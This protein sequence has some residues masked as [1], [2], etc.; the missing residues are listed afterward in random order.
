MFWKEVVGYN[1]TAYSML[2]IYVLG[3]T[4]ENLQRAYDDD[5]LHQD[6]MSAI[7]RSIVKE[8]GN[9]DVFLGK[10]YQLNQ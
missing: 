3:G 4:P 1:H 6:P 9:P 8:L 10:M 5:D 7:D 2:S